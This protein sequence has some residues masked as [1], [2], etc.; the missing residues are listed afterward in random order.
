MHYVKQKWSQYLVWPPFI[1]QHSHLKAFLWGGGLS[2]Y[3][4]V[5][6]VHD[7]LLLIFYNL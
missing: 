3:N 6:E 1:L 4:D 5:R 7:A 2:S